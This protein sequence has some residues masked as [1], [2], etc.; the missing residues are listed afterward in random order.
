MTTAP[1]P[2]HE[3]VR[4]EFPYPDHC[5]ACNRYYE[6]SLHIWPEVSLG[7]TAMFWLS[8]AALG[9]LLAFAVIGVQLS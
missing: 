8:C 9:A 1:P 4:G 5:A 6:N 3:F 7:S 2:R